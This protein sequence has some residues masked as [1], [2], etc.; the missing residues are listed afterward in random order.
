MKQIGKL[1]VLDYMKKIL[2]IFLFFAVLACGCS[3]ED[4]LVKQNEISEYVT[5]TATF[6]QNESRTYV[7][8]GN[9]MCWTKGDQIS[10]FP[11]KT[12]NYT[13]KFDGETGDN[14]GTFSYQNQPFGSGV[15]L[16]CNYAVYPYSSNTKIAANGEITTI[17]P[18]VQNYAE[19]SFGLGA[20][21]MVAATMDTDDTVL[22]FKNV[23]GCIKLQLYGDDV[24]VKSITLTG[25]NNENLAGKA[26]VKAA[27]GQ[28]PTLSMADDATHTITLECGESGVEIGTSPETATAFWIIVP[29]TT[30]EKGFTVSVTDV[31]GNEFSK[32]TSRK[33]EV[34][35]NVIKPMNAFHAR[36]VI[37]NNQIWY[38]SSNGEIVTPYATGVFGA[39]IMSNVYED[40]MGIITFDGDV[41]EIGERAFLACF[42]L[43][44]ITLPNSVTEIGYSAFYGSYLTEVTIPNSV[45]N[46][47]YSA[48]SACSLTDITIPHSVVEIGESAFLNNNFT[49]ITIPSSVTKIGEDAFSYCQTLSSIVVESG[50]PVYDSRNNCNAIIATATNA[51][52]AGCK[53]TVIPSNVTTIKDF[54]FGGFSS[55]TS[56][57]IPKSVTKI[58]TSA[59]Y[60]CESLSSIVV[61]SGNPVYD[62]R[63]NCNAII[64]T[65]T[66]TLV[67]GCKNTVIPE[68][69]TKIGISA[70]WGSSKLTSITIP[71]NVTAIETAAFSN[72]GSL[73]SITIPDHV[74]SI[75][76]KAFDFCTALKNVTI[77]NSVKSIGEYAFAACKSITSITIP[78]SVT[79]IE[80]YAFNNCSSLVKV[81][82]EA[83]TPPTI[84]FNSFEGCNSN[85]KFYVPAESLDDYKSATYWKDLSISSL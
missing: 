80:E 12:L 57:I 8:D 69:V 1:N 79:S 30:F 20:N 10:M 4:L 39:T 19:N 17:L 63:N 59:I 68:S 25:N 22:K 15:G 18:A 83:I 14:D 33:I 9:L 78:K 36:M 76:S 60:S 45:T 55:I 6:E 5:F 28:A 61:E 26:I 52:I 11:G 16:D 35:R 34:G 29:P 77:G 23:G 21:V 72:C 47:G 31:N 3:E 70:F 50:N 49:S 44:S 13:Y 2:S 7:E 24:T 38:T 66:N 81:D 32:S 64:E 56:I 82:V 85:I 27:Y 41:T 48:F 74:T 51:L 53:N 37:P 58:S 71:E 46:I 54:A 65:G 75:G 42:S 84:A 67:V 73:T 43:K 40:G 62:S